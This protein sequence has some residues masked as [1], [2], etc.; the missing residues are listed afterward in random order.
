MKQKIIIALTLNLALLFFAGKIFI[1]KLVA[2]DFV[3]WKFSA[4]LFA[5]IVF[6]F[7]TFMIIKELRLLKKIES[8]K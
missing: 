8:Q 3:L 1:S 4:S 5:V 2:E 6:S 7:F